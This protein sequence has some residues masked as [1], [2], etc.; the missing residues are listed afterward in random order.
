MG[1]DRIEAIGRPAP[2]IQIRLDVD[3]KEAPEGEVGEIAIKSWVVMD[4]YYK[5][6]QL[7]AEVLKDGWFY[8]G[9]LGRR[10]KEGLYY[11]VGRKKDMIKVSGQIVFP[12]EIEEAIHK[13]PSI[14]EAAV[15]GVPDALR[16]EAVKAFVVLK[17]GADAAEQDLKQFC[18]QHLA[19]FKLP[20]DF[21]FVGSLPKTRTG[22]VD[23]TLLKQR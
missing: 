7:T 2:W 1:S 18:R 4:G 23:K 12:A 15:I 6:P 5:D 14:R 10:D 19:H 16:G 8:T 13:H 22:K 9:D 17:E 20:Q 21:V 3:G 11:I